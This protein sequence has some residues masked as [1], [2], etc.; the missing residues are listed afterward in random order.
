MATASLIASGADFE[1]IARMNAMSGGKKSQ[2][3]FS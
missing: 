3:G 2:L 1:D